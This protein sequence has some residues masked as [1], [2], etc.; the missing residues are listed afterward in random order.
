LAS[1]RK[2]LKNEPV[3]PSA[4]NQCG[5]GRVTP[6]LSWPP[7]NARPGREKYIARSTM[8]GTLFSV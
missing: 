3:A 2:S 7:A 6:A 5:L 1:S 8:I 4:K